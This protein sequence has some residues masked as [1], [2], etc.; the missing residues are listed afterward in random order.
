MVRLSIQPSQPILPCRIGGP[1][2]HDTPGPMKI[3]HAPLSA[4]ALCLGIAALAGSLA[5]CGSEVPP[6]LT[7]FPE[8]TARG[9]VFEDQNGNGVRDEGETNR[10]IRSAFANST[11]KMV[12]VSLFTLSVLPVTRTQ[13]LEVAVIGGVVKRSEVAPAIGLERSPEMPAY[14]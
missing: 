9:V 10:P 12:A 1:F 7:D 4:S 8:G 13:K 5:S 2:P 14:H 11:A 3:F 6:P